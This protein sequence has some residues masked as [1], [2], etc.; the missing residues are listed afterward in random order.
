MPDAAQLAQ[1]HWNET[2]LFLTEE[3]RYSAYPWLYEVA[4]FRKHHGDALWS[5]VSLWGLLRYGGEWKQQIE[6]SEAPVHIDLYTGR[7]LRRLFGRDISIEKY[8][9]RPFKLL[10]PLFG[11]FLVVKGQKT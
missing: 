5:S 7:E 6:N 9:C 3:A 1:S 10:A 11:W 8:E 4:E 2:P